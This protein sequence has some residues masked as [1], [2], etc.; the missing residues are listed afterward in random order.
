[1]QHPSPLKISLQIVALWHLGIRQLTIIWNFTS[2]NGIA[3]AK[4]YN[5]LAFV[6]YSDFYF[7]SNSHGTAFAVYIFLLHNYII[8]SRHLAFFVSKAKMI[9]KDINI[10][11]LGQL[12]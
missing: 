5:P 11:D 3:A 4:V 1:M 12:Y 9:C 8:T 2:S 6:G 10:V 7:T